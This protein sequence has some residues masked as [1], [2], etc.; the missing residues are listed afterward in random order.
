MNQKSCRLSVDWLMIWL[1]SSISYCSYFSCCYSI[2][3]CRFHLSS[4]I[5]C[6]NKYC[7]K[8]GLHRRRIWLFF[9][10]LFL[11]PGFSLFF[12]DVDVLLIHRKQ[13]EEILQSASELL[14]QRFQ[15]FI[16]WRKIPHSSWTGNPF[17]TGRLVIEILN[18][19]LSAVL[20]LCCRNKSMPVYICLSVWCHNTYIY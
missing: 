13:L 6:F 7:I 8:R 1:K 11:C 10:I 9:A 14:S 5:T 19:K 2:N 3:T 17:D 20:E 15:D 12:V 18:Q 4:C 16:V